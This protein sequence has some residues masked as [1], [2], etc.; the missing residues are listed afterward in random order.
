MS[1][2]KLQAPLC[3]ALLTL[4]STNLTVKQSPSRVNPDQLPPIPQNENLA[5]APIDP[6]IDK[7]FFI[8]G[9]AA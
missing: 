4:R 8:S 3:C 2:R 1:Q 5:P 7:W 9:A 6:S